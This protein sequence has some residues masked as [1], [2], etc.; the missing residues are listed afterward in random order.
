MKSK[1]FNKHRK[2]FFESAMKLSDAKSIEYT[3]SSIDRLANFK[4]V[5]SRLGISPMQALM[6]YVLKHVDAI[7]NDAKTDKQFSDESFYSRAQDVCNY[8][9]LATAL[10]QDT[11][12]K[13]TTPHD[14]NKIEPNR[15][16]TSGATRH[17]SDDAE[18]TKWSKLSRS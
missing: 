7:C 18:Q 8:M 15:N 4:N 14:Q 10:H 11:H 9:V 5:A 13:G 16:R 1:E 17:S 12:T 6:V 2:E 3:I